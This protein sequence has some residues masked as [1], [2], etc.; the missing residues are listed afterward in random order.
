MDKKKMK[1]KKVVVAMSGGVDSSVAAALLKEQGYDVIGV[2][3]KLFTLPKD[4]CRSENLRSCCG[5]QATEDAH[6]VAVSLGIFH[7]IVDFRNKFEK[8]VIEDFCEEYSNGRTPNPCI[9]CN[10]YIKF[11]FLMGKLKAF[12]ADYLATG[13]HAR[14]EYD[15][16]SG[17]YLLKKGRDRNKDQS[18]FLYPLTQKQLSRTLMPIGNLT[19]DEVRKKAQKLGLPVAHRRESQEICFVPDNDYVRFLRQRIPG[20][21]GPGPIVDLENRV[22]GQ[23]KGIAHFTIGQRSGMGI[24]APHPLYVLSIQSDKKTIVIGPSDE[25]YEKALA[26]SRVNLISMS[27]I[28]RPLSVKA[29]IRY[30]H[31]E[32][33]A[34]LTPLD[35]DQIKVEF[36]KPQRAI[37]PGQSVVFYDGDVVVGGGIIYKSGER[38]LD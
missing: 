24:A 2:T 10:Q 6:R 18:Y 13:H 21:F 22:L 37:T 36:E 33:K 3:M 30:K 20:A 4:Y 17:R 14:I 34:L 35:K 16:K 31:R 8:S 23:H 19:K 7:F 29:K 27:K 12:E 5:W 11:D 32:A 15:P 28:T 26:A 9:R 38:N 25:L 1:Q